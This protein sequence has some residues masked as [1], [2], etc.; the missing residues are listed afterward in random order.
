M[1]YCL[2]FGH[3]FSYESAVSPPLKDLCLLLLI[4][5]ISVLILDLVPGGEGRPGGEA[6]HHG[7]A[8]LHEPG[9][10]VQRQ[11]QGS[12]QQAGGETGQLRP[13]VGPAH[14][15]SG[16]QQL[17]GTNQCVI[18]RNR[19]D[20]QSYIRLICQACV[21]TDSRLWGFVFFLFFSESN[22]CSN[23]TPWG[24]ICAAV[25]TQLW[26]NLSHG[27]CNSDMKW[28]ERIGWTNEGAENL[29]EVC[30]SQLSSQSRR[31]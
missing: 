16:G 20:S 24:L 19:G 7:Q 30:V 3:L 26:W 12:S 13:A 17:P 21:L 9:P 29:R 1:S 5:L 2:F 6:S 8:V 4:P 10:L 22:L 28:L 27:S 11:E 23:Q 14:P 18:G 25:K 31:D 15:E